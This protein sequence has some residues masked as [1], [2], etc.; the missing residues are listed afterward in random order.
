MYTNMEAYKTYSIYLWLNDK[1]TKKQKIWTL[2]AYKLVRNLVV[3]EFWA[4]TITEANGV[5]SH[6]S[7]EIVEEKTI[8]IEL[9]TEKSVDEFVKTLKAIF[10]QESVLVKTAIENINF[11]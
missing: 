10:N 1:D 11:A 6:E 4:W 8:K 2:D 9:I 5:F 3:S 7:W